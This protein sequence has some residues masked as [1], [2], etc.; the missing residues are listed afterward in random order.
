M[1]INWS[2]VTLYGWTSVIRKI[3]CKFHDCRSLMSILLSPP[4]TVHKR[5]I[6]LILLHED[7]SLQCFIPAMEFVF[8]LDPAGELLGR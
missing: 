3:Q 6:N 7:V 8:L 5:I 4:D 2:C 1:D